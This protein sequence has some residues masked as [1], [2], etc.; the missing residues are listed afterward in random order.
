ML[1]QITIAA[2][3]PTQNQLENKVMISELNYKISSKIKN[4][5]NFI[6]QVQI[7]VINIIAKQSTQTKY[8]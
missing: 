3:V 1:A 5:E 2:A 4:N 8:I 7:F 6:N